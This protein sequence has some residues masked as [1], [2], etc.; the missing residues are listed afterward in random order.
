MLAQA[1]AGIRGTG[2]KAVI[3][4]LL[5]CILC[6]GSIGLE[7]GV[8]RQAAGFRTHVLVCMGACIA[9]MTGEYTTLYV[10]GSGDASRIGAQVISGIGFLGAGTIFSTDVTHRIRGLTTAAGLWAAACLGLAIGVGYFEIAIFGTLAICITMVSF[11]KV[12]GWFYSQSRTMVVYLELDSM[13][14]VQGMTELL[15]I[16][17]LR[18]SSLE[19]QK[20]KSGMAGSVG[21]SLTVKRNKIDDVDMEEIIN[22]TPG[23][24]YY[25][26]VF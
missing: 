4:K 23:L 16:H 22:R 5:L 9:M 25:E 21:V 2:L 10:T 8:N 24:L 17:G 26:N 11:K 14:R 7:R 19:I 20:A 3:F 6:G 13:E 15:R 18:I 1:L 12:D